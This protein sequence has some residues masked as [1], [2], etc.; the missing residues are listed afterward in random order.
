MV[1][2]PWCR[3]PPPGWDSV[4]ETPAPTGGG[5]SD[6]MFGTTRRSS[7]H[8]RQ[9]SVRGNSRQSPPVTVVNRKPAWRDRLR[10]VRDAERTRGRVRGT[11]PIVSGSR[12][13]ACSDHR[14]TDDTAVSRLSTVTAVSRPSMATSVSRPKT[15]PLPA[16][17][18]GWLPRRSDGAVR[19]SGLGSTTGAGSNQWGFVDDEAKR[20]RAAGRAVQ[21]PTRDAPRV[22]RGR[23]ARWRTGP[24]WQKEHTPSSLS[25][26]R[27]GSVWTAAGF[28]AGVG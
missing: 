12:R 8:G 2:C 17:A 16:R 11:A 13:R 20:T 28:Y 10:P 26:R 7:L 24:I 25:A 21:R 14:T 5:K 18:A 19:F 6:W 1:V 23:P 15:R 27:F 4:V 9:S 3:G 22:F